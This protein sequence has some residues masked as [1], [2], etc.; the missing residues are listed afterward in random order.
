[1]ELSCVGNGTVPSSSFSSYSM[2]HKER[3]LS[4]SH[5]G[6]MITP[7]MHCLHPSYYSERLLASGCG[8]HS[9]GWPQ[10]PREGSQP[11]LQATPYTVLS[12]EL[13]G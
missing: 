4:G 5:V 2:L 6:H 1:M 11:T 7:D 10:I 13:G 8:T 12:T 3:A 9:L